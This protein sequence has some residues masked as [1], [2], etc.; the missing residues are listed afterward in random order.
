MQPF[1]YVI[2]ASVLKLEK[3]IRS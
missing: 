2:K 3:D 1:N